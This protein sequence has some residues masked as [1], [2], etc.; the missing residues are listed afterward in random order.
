[1]KLSITINSM[2][3][4]LLLYNELTPS[5]RFPMHHGIAG[6][7]ASTGEIINIPDAYADPRF[8]K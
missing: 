2:E 8:L 3:I 7:V 6:M 5:L 1:M 4:T